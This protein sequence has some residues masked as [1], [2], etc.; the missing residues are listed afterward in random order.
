[1]HENRIY[2]VRLLE[3]WEEH[4]KIIIGVDYDDTI[5]PYTF[6]EPKDIERLNWVIQAVIN[7]QKKGAYV[8]IFTASNPEKFEKILSYCSEKG[9]HVD[10]INKN[11]IPLPYGNHGKIYANIFLDDRA[12]LVEATAILE[13]VTSLKK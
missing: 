4:G 6:R 7:A 9:I 12:G 1:M 5:S 13:H 10:S 11:P 3:E 2:A 8:V